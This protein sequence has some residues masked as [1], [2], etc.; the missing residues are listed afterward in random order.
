VEAAALAHAGLRDAA[1]VAPDSVH[2]LHADAAG[3][4]AALDAGA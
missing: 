4:A 1:V 2:L 3:L